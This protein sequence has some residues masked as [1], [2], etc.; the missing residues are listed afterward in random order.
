MSDR[1]STKLFLGGLLTTELK[2][3]LDR[4]PEWTQQQTYHPNHFKLIQHNQ[5][6]YLGIYLSPPPYPLNDLKES[7]ETLKNDLQKFCPKFSLDNWT[8][9]IIPQV[10]VL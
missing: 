1:I 3:Q 8:V 7:V 2:F 10:F 6:E 4:N 9:T 5:K